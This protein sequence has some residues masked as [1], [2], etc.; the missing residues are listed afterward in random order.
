MAEFPKSVVLL[1]GDVVIDG[2]AFPYHVAD[3]AAE[4]Y[5]ML[6][7]ADDH[8]FYLVLKVLLPRESGSTRTTI[9]DQ[10]SRTRDLADM[11]DRG[12]DI[13]AEPPANQHLITGDQELGLAWRGG[14]DAMAS[15]RPR[16]ANPH[17]IA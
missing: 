7:A 14:F 10:R 17:R 8:M 13:A 5:D 9:D 16:A 1:D 2:E 11:W 4:G 3:P 15:G 12:Y 6:E